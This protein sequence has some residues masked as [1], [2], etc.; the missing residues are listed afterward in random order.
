M[1]EGC[2]WEELESSIR[3]WPTA[4]ED[5]ALA[6]VYMAPLVDINRGNGVVVAATCRFIREAGVLGVVEVMGRLNRTTTTWRN[7]NK[8]F[9]R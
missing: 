4:G 5:L 9:S 6:A 2:C 3:R 8:S 1:K 7:N